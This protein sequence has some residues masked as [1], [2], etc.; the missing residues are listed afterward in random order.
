MKSSFFPFYRKGDC[1]PTKRWRRDGLD[2]DIEKL[3]WLAGRKLLALSGRKGPVG[4]IRLECLDGTA[5]NP[6]EAF[7]Q[8]RQEIVRLAELGLD[9]LRE[10]AEG[11]TDP[12]TGHEKMALEKAAAA[13]VLEREIP[14]ALGRLREIGMTARELGRLAQ[15]LAATADAGRM[16]FFAGDVAEGLLEI[17]EAGESFGGPETDALTGLA[18]ETI[19]MAEW[20]VDAYREEA[21]DRL[22][23][24]Q[25]MEEAVESARSGAAAG[26]LKRFADESAGPSPVLMQLFSDFGRCAEHAAAL[27]FSMTAGGEG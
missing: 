9:A 10:A 1:Y 26:Y 24:V 21:F 25:T 14:P 17:K 4:E 12:G 23:M 8:G 6:H 16:A 19:R 5:A 3:T 15:M 11:L 2:L 22:G 27:A 13:A 18:G 7:R 20:A